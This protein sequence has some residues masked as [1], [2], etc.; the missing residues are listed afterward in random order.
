MNEPVEKKDKFGNM[1]KISVV[2]A[3]YNRKDILPITLQCLSRQTLDPEEF[4]VILVDDGSTDGTE[5][6][7]KRLEGQLPYD[8]TYLR[9]PNSGI[10]YTQNRGIRAARA[11][12]V[13]LIADDIH[14][15]PQALSQHLKDHRDNPEQH[16]AILGKVVQSPELPQTVF[17]KQWD[18][19]RFRELGGHREVPCFLF[20]AC[21]VSFKREFMLEKG[22]F[23]EELVKDGA[24]AHEDVELGYR[25]ERHGMKLLY[26]PSALA[27]HYHCVSLEHAMRT[28]FNKGLS[29]VKFRE[30]VGEPELTVRYHV[31]HPSYLRDYGIL[32]TGR[33]N[34]MGM[35]RSPVRLAINQ[36]L[37]IMA[38]NNLTVPL[39]WIPIMKAAEKNSLL[40]RLMHT[41]MY[42][43][44][45][46]HFFHKGVARSAAKARK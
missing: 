23:N 41:Q 44:V 8:F 29:W 16:V 34:L 27:Y 22:M 43:C 4:E 25:L 15:S 28:A 3:S 45:I 12:L 35:D 38:F 42:R 33:H 18:P 11:P 40:A 26:N 5:E 24:Y 31:L 9:H 6:T 10:C 20:F 1:P 32:F 14:M 46:S 36:M 37:R 19:F 7:V 17:L 39:F 30:E 13:C 2:I 21:N